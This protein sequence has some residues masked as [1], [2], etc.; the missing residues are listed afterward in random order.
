MIRQ[1]EAGDE[2]EDAVDEIQEKYYHEFR[3]KERHLYE[4]P[5]EEPEEEPVKQET[6][7]LSVQAKEFVPASKKAPVKQEKKLE[8]V[9]MPQQP[10]KQ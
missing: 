2:D 7:Q 5:G 9:V 1:F 6:Q 10:Q 3:Q 8:E 4:E